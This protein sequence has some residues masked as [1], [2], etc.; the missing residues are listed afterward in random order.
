MEYFISGDVPPPPA[1]SQAPPAYP[2]TQ[3]AY[4][5]QQPGYSQPQTGYGYGQPQTGFQGGMY[6]QPGY[7]NQNQTSVLV[8][9]ILVLHTVVKPRQWCDLVFWS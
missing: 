4:P 1:Y 8:S 6:N 9:V 5:P 3:Q 2:G 7:Y